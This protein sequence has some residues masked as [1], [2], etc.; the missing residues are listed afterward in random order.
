MEYKDLEKKKE[1]ELVEMLSQERAKLYELRLKLSVNQIKDVRE[2]REV[3]K[4]IAQVLS[5]LRCIKTQ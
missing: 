1:S 5:Q 4:T 2:I 3:R